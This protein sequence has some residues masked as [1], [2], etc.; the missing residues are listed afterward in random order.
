VPSSIEQCPV[1]PA[2]SKTRRRT[3]QRDVELMTKEKVLG[4]RHRDLNKSAMNIPSACKTANI[5]QNDAMILPHHTNPG[6]MEF[7]EK[8]GHRRGFF[9][10]IFCI[11]GKQCAS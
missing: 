11:L 1:G 8:T 7:S 10:G 5:T 9:S 6:G 3:S 2:Q 4:L